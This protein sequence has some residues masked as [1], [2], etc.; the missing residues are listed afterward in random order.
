MGLR[1]TAVTSTTTYRCRSR[2]ARL[3]KLVWKWT[4][5][6]STG[7]MEFGDPLHSA[8]YA[9]CLYQG[10][11]DDVLAELPVAADATKWSAVGT[12]GYKYRD[13]TRMSSGVQKI[14]LASSA[15][16]RA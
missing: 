2:P 9:L 5:G 3:D 1:S 7:N 15:V 16:N 11:T 4:K 10:A 14:N 13:K 6:Q 12:K 8:D